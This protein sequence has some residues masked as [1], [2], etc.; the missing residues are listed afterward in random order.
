MKLCAH[1][2]NC[3]L[4]VPGSR[5]YARKTGQP[6][7]TGSFRTLRGPFAPF[8]V[9]S[10]IYYHSQPSHFNLPT[11][12][13]IQLTH[14]VTNATF[15]P[16]LT[17]KSLEHYIC[18]P[19][20]PHKPQ[21]KLNNV[22]LRYQGQTPPT[23]GPFT[24]IDSWHPLN[25][26]WNGRSHVQKITTNKQIPKPSQIK[27]QKPPTPPH[28]RENRAQF[29]PTHHH[30]QRHYSQRTSDC[31]PISTRH[32]KIYYKPEIYMRAKKYWYNNQNCTAVPLKKKP[33]TSQ[34]AQFAKG[35]TTAEI[36]VCAKKILY[37][38]Q[39]SLPKTRFHH[40][41][42]HHGPTPIPPATP[43]GGHH[44]REMHNPNHHLNLRALRRQ[45]SHQ[46]LKHG[47][48][49]TL[50]RRH[51][52]HLNPVLLI[53]L[54]SLP[55]AAACQDCQGDFLQLPLALG[56]LTVLAVNARTK[57]YT[58]VRTGWTLAKILARQMEKHKVDA[59]LISEAH[60]V[61]HSRPPSA[62]DREG[63][64]QVAATVYK[65]HA[66]TLLSSTTDKRHGLTAIMLNSTLSQHLLTQLSFLLIIATSMRRTNKY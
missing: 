22:G 19:L 59:M 42:P 27:Y 15:L 62:N 60:G 35:S 13:V 66:V 57:L 33:P 37:N 61:Q 11:Q 48:V 65:D 47:P 38:N 32:P 1:F 58:T 12:C 14:H 54:I 51:L 36:Y 23:A 6:H 16:T 39:I 4:W 7:P 5:G 21:D 43:H 18:L 63:E 44:Q 8:G 64:A 45:I 28:L 50:A 31:Q 30:S 9:H 17:N 20:L 24:S 2:G 26:C 41:A 46:L 55:A 25:I 10:L 52:P 3:P 49:F 34:K 53:L 40:T 56:N 29:P